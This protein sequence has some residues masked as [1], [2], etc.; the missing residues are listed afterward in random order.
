MLILINMDIVIMQLA[1]MHV[2]NFHYQKVA[3]GK[4]P[5]FYGVD[6]SYSVLVDNENKDILVLG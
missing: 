2:H 4:M 6:N 1:S 3:G 5:L